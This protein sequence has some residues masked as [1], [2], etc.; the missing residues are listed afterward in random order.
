V[1]SLLVISPTHNCAN[2]L[3]G[4][5]VNVTLRT[6]SFS[7]LRDDEMAEIRVK[8]VK[9]LDSRGGSASW[10]RL[11]FGHTLN[12]SA[13][14]VCGYERTFCVCIWDSCT[15]R[16]ECLTYTPNTTYAAPLC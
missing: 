1:R 11:D 5:S 10:R 3:Y 7:V 12:R 2:F 14:A 15:R 8:L 6:E 9:C 16:T 4:K 13:G